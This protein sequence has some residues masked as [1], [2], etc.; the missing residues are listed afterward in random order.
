MTRLRNAGIGVFYIVL[1]VALIWLSIAIYNRDFSNV[2]KVS[3]STDSVGSSLQKGSDVEVRGILVGTVTGVSTDGDGARISLDIDGSRAKQLP[4]DMTAELLPK[5]LFGERYVDLVLPATPTGTLRGGDVIP[6]DT[7][8][9]GVELQQV[10]NRLLPVLQAVQ[11]AQLSTLLGE[12]SEALDGRGTQL[13]QT[14]HIFTTY[15]QRFSPEVPQLTADIAAFGQVADTY[16]N[17][18][19]DLLTALDDLTTTSATLVADRQQLAALFANVQSASDIVSGV[20]ATNAQNIITLSSNSLPTLRVLAAYS[21]EFPCISRSLAAFVPVADKAFGAGTNQPGLHITLKVVPSLGAYLPGQ[22]GSVAATGPATCPTSDAPVIGS[23]TALAALSEPSGKVTATPASSTKVV[24]DTGD[25]G[26]A[27]SP[28]EN[29]VIAEL[30]GPTVGV[31]PS[32]FPKW[33]SLLLGP[34]LR[35]AVVTVQ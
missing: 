9:R 3:V 1:V 2:V 20:V 15:L 13:G 14:V 22:Q 34:E 29:E 28:A 19:P 11:P 10:F 6:Q 18:A 4:A 8:A 35:G 30:V 31:S 32:S 7:S 23:G 25:I 21:S 16:A 17:A 33:A 27:N 26:T 5:T 12:L 24:A